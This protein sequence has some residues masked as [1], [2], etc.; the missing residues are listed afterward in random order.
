MDILNAIYLRH[1]VRRYTDRPVEKEKAERLNELTEKIN[2]KTG[3]HFQLIL[4]EPNAFTGTMAHY[5]SFEGVRNYFVLAGPKK[6]DREVGYYGEIL[7]VLAQMLGLNT[8]WVALTFNKRK[9]EYKLNKGEKFYVVISLGYGQT[10][11]REHKSK[12]LEKIAEITPA[13]PEWY[14]NGIDAVMK[15][16][17]AVNQQ[18]FHFSLDGDKV[19]SKAGSGFYT[20]MDLG[21][22]QYHFDVGAERNCFGLERMI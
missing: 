1:S 20:D 14:K 10:Q 15:A 12:P 19:I 17:T 22:A 8:C 16:P 3:L 4:N 18:K 7:V 13:S 21:I 9:T 11:G 2:R 6:M 5:G